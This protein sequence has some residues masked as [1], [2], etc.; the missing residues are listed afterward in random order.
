M[1]VEVTKLT[2]KVK[3][4]SQTTRK[5]WLVQSR[6]KEICEGTDCFLSFHQE[7]KQRGKKE[8]LNLK[9]IFNVGIGANYESI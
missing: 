7:N 3:L 4:N 6:K 1:L 9:K 8:L 2:E 5:A